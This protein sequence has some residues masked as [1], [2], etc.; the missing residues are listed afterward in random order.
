M[1]AEAKETQ[2]LLASPEVQKAIKEAAALAVAEA[3][4]AI[5]KAGQG[6][7]ITTPGTTLEELIKAS[8][9]QR[10]EVH[11]KPAATEQLLSQLATDHARIVEVA[12]A[13][14]QVTT[15]AATELATDIIRLSR[16]KVVFGFDRDGDARI[17]EVPPELENAGVYDGF[18]FCEL[19]GKPG[20]QVV[21]QLERKEPVLPLGVPLVLKF[22]SGNETRIVRVLLTDEPAVAAA[23]DAPPPLSP[24]PRLPDDQTPFGLRDEPNM[25]LSDVRFF[26]SMRQRREEA[27]YDPYRM[28]D[29]PPPSHY[30]DH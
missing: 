5:R 4:A 14:G 13:A 20:Y 17:V 15:S 8:I 11:L 1:A 28:P 6:E 22:A 23:D 18:E 16:D 29:G 24:P 26:Q 21:D 25:P 30:W 7:G 3:I 9:H 12:E 10:N 27:P 2:T 19:D